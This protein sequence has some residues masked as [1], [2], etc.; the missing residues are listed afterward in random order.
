MKMEGEQKMKQSQIEYQRS[1]IREEAKESIRE[2]SQQNTRRL[3]PLTDKWKGKKA[4][5]AHMS[6]TN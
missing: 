1:V 2:L 5:R 4:V 6:K 3:Q